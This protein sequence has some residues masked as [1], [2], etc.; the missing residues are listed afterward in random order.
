MPEQ[1]SSTSAKGG[2]VEN[3]Q[4]GKASCGVSRKAHAWSHRGSPSCAALGDDEGDEMKRLIDKSRVTSKFSRGKFRT[5]GN[6]S[7]RKTNFISANSRI[8]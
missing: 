4:H 6:F 8:R 2:S 5:A 7:V 1:N 3:N